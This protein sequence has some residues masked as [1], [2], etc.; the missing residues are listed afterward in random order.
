MTNKYERIS[1][2][3]LDETYRAFFDGLKGGSLEELVKTA[4]GV[5][6]LPLVL[7]DENSRLL[8]QYPPRPLGEKMWDVFWWEKTPGEEILQ[9]YQRKMLTDKPADFEPFYYQ[10]EDPEES[11]YILGQISFQGKNYGYFT[12]FMFDNPLDEDDIARAK[13]F[14]D[15]LGIVMSRENAAHT[16]GVNRA[17]YDGLSGEQGEA[18]W[19][20]AIATLDRN[21][22][23]GYAL[24]VMPIGE[25]TSQKTYAAMSVRRI[26]REIPV[27]IY[28]DCLVLLFGQIKSREYRAQ[29]YPPMA[30]SEELLRPSGEGCGI[31][32]LFY[33]LEDLGNAFEQAYMTA[34]GA[35]G[36]MVF[37]EQIAPEPVFRLASRYSR[38][39]AFL[40]PALY[41]LHRYDTENR[42]EYFQTLRAYSLFL[43]NK[44]R[45]AQELCI[46]RNTLLYRLNRI[47]EIF[48]LPY[49]EP[50][51]A[52]HL[53]NSFQ[54]WDV[55][56]RE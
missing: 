22:S 32:A 56:K 41:E 54:L 28:R 30:S 36:G 24:M 35:E 38:P 39:E 4:E 51:T 33:H 40:A 2:M 29:E 49:E 23:G 8:Y 17:L 15:A 55:M 26:S 12:I 46:H 48:G 37:Y 3:T 53:L 47:E 25:K 31:S 14:S 52:L 16:D 5:F 21:L 43:H 45:A 19:A 1:L 18:L 13:I 7:H 27:T 11:R 6:G 44:E 20:Q 50:R 42:T 34:L 10:P 9:E